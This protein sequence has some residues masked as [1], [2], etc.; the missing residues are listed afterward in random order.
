MKNLPRNVPGLPDFIPDDWR[1]RIMQYPEEQLGTTLGTFPG[2]FLGI[3]V[4]CPPS[5]TKNTEYV[6]LVHGD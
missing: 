5:Q 2:T 6:R 4:M 1:I 3:R